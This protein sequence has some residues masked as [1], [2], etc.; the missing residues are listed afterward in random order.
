MSAAEL[1]KLPE[2]E[3]NEA[4]FAAQGSKGRLTVEELGKL[5][6]RILETNDPEEEAALRAE[7]VKG[8]YGNAPHA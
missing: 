8:F 4:L 5:T 6:K 1:A 2:T 3:R 7:L